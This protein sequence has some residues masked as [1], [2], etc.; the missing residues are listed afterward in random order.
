MSLEQ[1]LLH[2]PNRSYLIADCENLVRS[3]VSKKTGLSGLAV[4]GAFA[5]VQRLNPSFVNSA[6][7]LLINEFVQQLAPFYDH[8]Q[9][10]HHTRL[11]DFLNENADAVS[12]A[13]LQTTDARVRNAEN[14]SLKK[15]YEKLRPTGKKHVESALPGIAHI[16]EKYVS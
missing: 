2:E 6:I 14:R 16:L 1:T 11:Q 3:E 7:N 15:A 4:K 12:S 5:F 8:F 9:Q 13:L 10:S